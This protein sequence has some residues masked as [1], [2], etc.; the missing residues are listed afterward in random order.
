[1]MGSKDSTSAL[2]ELFEIPKDV[3]WDEITD[4]VLVLCELKC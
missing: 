4:K 1:M 3:Q 2:P